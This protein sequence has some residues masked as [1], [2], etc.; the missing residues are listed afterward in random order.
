MIA[1]KT[2]ATL[3]ML[4]LRWIARVGSL[5]SIGL[6]LLFFIGEGFHPAKIAPKQWV[7]MIFFPAGVVAGMIIAWWK[8]GVGA[9]I[10]LLSLFA[11][12]A[13]YGFL[14]GSHIRG[15]AFIAFAAPGFLFL[16]YSIMLRGKFT[17]ATS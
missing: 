3:T 1:T 15:W 13:V 4:G 8:E 6:I 5:L 10:T 9:G 11:F 12:Y 7:G 17:E 16:L 2:Y 14:L